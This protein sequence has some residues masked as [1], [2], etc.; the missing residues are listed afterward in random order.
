MANELTF[1]G[2]LFVV[3]AWGSIVALMIFC[4]KRILMT[5]NRKN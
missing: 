3:A 1:A 5:R 4:F 2:I